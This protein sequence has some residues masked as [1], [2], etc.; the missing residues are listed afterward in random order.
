MNKVW[1]LIGK[2]TAHQNEGQ[3]KGTPVFGEHKEGNVKLQLEML[4]KHPGPT[5]SHILLAKAHFPSH[6]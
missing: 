4:S 2:I 3:E 5:S 1:S 6:V